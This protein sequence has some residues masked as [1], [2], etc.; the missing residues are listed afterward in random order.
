MTTDFLV[1]VVFE[2]YSESGFLNAKIEL[3]EKV[4]INGKTQRLIKRQGD[5]KNDMNVKNI[6]E[7]LHLPDAC[8]KDNLSSKSIYATTTCNFPPVDVRNIEGLTIV[9]DL[10]LVTEEIKSLKQKSR[11]AQQLTDH[12]LKSDVGFLSFLPSPEKM[13]SKN[14]YIHSRLFRIPNQWFQTNPLMQRNYSG[15]LLGLVFWKSS[16]S[17]QRWSWGHNLRGQG[18]RMEKSSRPRT[19]FSRTDPLEAK[20][21]NGRS[22]GQ[23]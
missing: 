8:M 14:H 3:F 2:L 20:N 7:F 10:N 22:R 1:K 19:D 15:K 16:M 17:Y 6:L 21:R 5:N 9:H 4:I 12:R 23:G 13:L 18:Q 11:A